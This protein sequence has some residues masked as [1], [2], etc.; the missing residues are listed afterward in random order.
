MI[1]NID[2][3]SLINRLRHN[4]AEA[5]DALYNLYYDRV[6][7]YSLQISKSYQKASDIT[8]DVFLKLWETRHKIKNDTSISTYL[9][10]IARNNLVSEFRKM[11]NSS[12]YENYIRLRSS[13]DSQ[14]GLEIE[15]AD[16]VKQIRECMT[17]MPENQ[18]VVVKMSRFEYMSNREIAEKLGL[19]EQTVKNRLVLGLK[20]MRQW[21]RKNTIILVLISSILS[22]LL[23]P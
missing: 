22:D 6:F 8:Q 17:L 18:R 2:E 10:R 1:E 20:F 11:V 12:N 19:S 15:Y 13:V 23:H 4:S 16:F 21:L 9:F 5:F 14:E 3:K 7:T